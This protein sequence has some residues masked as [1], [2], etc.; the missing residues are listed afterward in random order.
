MPTV[1]VMAVH[2]VYWSHCLSFGSWGFWMSVIS[3]I[4]PYWSHCPGFGTWGSWISVISLHRSLL[5]TLSW[6]WYLGTPDSL[7]QPYH[8]FWEIL[9]FTKMSHTHLSKWPKFLLTENKD[10]NQIWLLDALTT[11]TGDTK[12]LLDLVTAHSW[13][14][15]IQTSY[16]E[17]LGI[18]IQMQ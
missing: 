9:H 3:L 7:S 4:G 16:W 17:D 5:V 18:I 14:R 10:R 15:H 13:F 12:L 8:Y 11:V 2:G 6:L 1:E